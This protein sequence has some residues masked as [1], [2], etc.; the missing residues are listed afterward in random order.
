[1]SSLAGNLELLKA[2]ECRIV[3]DKIGWCE[4]RPWIQN[5]TL[6]ENILFDA[7]FDEERYQKCVEACALKPD[8]ELL[9]DGDST[10]IGERVN[11]SWNLKIIFVFRELTCP[12]VSV[13]V[14]AWH[15]P[16]TNKLTSTYSTI[17]CPQLIRQ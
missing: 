3:A 9:A 11:I 5:R 2:D 14:L 17:L 4:Q 7:G 16:S 12:A 8:M 15:V 10:L 6:R 1:L 13:L